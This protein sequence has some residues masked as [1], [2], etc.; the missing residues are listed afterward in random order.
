MTGSEETGVGV[1]TAAGDTRRLSR[2][3]EHRIAIR[4][5]MAE[6]MKAWL[7]ARVKA[8]AIPGSK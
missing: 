6:A 7:I 2:T 8:L 3:T 1:A 5:M 4:Q